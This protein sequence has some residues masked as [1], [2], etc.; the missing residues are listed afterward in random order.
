MTWQSLM[1]VIMKGRHIAVPEA[2]QKC[3]L[4][5]LCINHMGIEKLNY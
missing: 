5:Q 1:G 4:Q 3:P 2:L